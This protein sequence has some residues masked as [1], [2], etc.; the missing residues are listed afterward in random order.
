[1]K[2]HGVQSGLSDDMSPLTTMVAPSA[3]NIHVKSELEPLDQSGNML[4]LLDMDD[5]SPMGVDPM[6]I[7]APVS[8]SMEDDSN[9]M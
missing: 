1:M 9:D 3:I 5:T 4:H 2:A 7:S 8:P 6:L